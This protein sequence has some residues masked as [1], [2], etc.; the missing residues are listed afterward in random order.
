MR[1]L[2]QHMNPRARRTFFLRGSGGYSWKETARFLGTTANSA[3]VLFNQA[4]GKA[5]AH[6]MKLKGSTRRPG[7][8]GKAHA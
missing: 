6:I 4:V 3:Q 2:L 7:E 1:E 8:G 5:R